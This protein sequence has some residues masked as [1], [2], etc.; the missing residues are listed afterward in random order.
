VGVLQG[1]DHAWVAASQWWL[2]CKALQQRLAARRMQDAYS[3]LILVL[4][5]SYC[6][7]THL[8]SMPVLTLAGGGACC[9]MLMVCRLCK[10]IT[11]LHQGTTVFC[12]EVMLFVCCVGCCCRC[13][14][15]RSGG[16]SWVQMDQETYD[17]FIQEAARRRI[18]TTFARSIAVCGYMQCIAVA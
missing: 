9:T 16:H 5:C 1:E 11:F 8:L 14:S 10:R 3:S 12:A 6:C 4:G 2:S 17:K 7:S 18:L 13:C 15:C